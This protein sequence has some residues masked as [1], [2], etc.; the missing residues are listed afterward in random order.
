VGA[1]PLAGPNHGAGLHGQGFVV[2]AVLAA[3]ALGLSAVLC[4]SRI[5]LF[6]SWRFVFPVFLCHLCI[7]LSFPRRRARAGRNP[8]WDLNTWI[9]ACAGMTKRER[10]E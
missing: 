6:F 3:E 8:S 7:F 4:P 2:I 10:E 1:R 5:L 9:P